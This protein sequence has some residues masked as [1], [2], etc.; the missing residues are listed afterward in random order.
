AGR[1]AV[2]TAPGGS[3]A[4]RVRGARTRCGHAAQRRAGLG[5]ILHARQRHRPAGRR[6]LLG[7]QPAGRR[8][9]RR[10]GGRSPRPSRTGHCGAGRPRR[11]DGLTVPRAAGVPR[12]AAPASRPA[13]CGVPG[14]GGGDRRLPRQQHRGRPGG[15]RCAGVGPA[16][17]LPVELQRGPRW[18]SA[19]GVAAG[20]HRRA[21]HDR[22]DP[23]PRTIGRPRRPAAAPRPPPGR[24][25][26]H[27]RPVRV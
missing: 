20:R 14:A 18:W 6:V 1:R 15:G 25:D 2:L 7:R 23:A 26:S 3:A 17:R 12:R 21:G 8:G 16:G 5:R 13:G 22:G 4:L 11:G 24:R 27:E 9:L 10:A 19:G